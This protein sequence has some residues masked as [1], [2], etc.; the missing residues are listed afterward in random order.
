VFPEQ[1]EAVVKETQVLQ[2]TRRRHGYCRKHEGD[3]GTAGNTKET[4]V[5]QETRR[6]HGYCRKHEVNETK[7]RQRLVNCH[8]KVATSP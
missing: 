1:E 6:R 5:L 8:V 4:R 3:T 2:E 7:K